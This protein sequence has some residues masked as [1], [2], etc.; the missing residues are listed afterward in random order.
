MKI[1]EE[2][3]S[4]QHRNPSSDFLNGKQEDENLDSLLRA[5]HDKIETFEVKMDTIVEQNNETNRFL[6]ELIDILK[7]QSLDDADVL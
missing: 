4:V 5:M 3:C 1:T 2:H 6:K 7:P